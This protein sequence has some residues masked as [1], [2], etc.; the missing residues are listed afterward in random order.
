MRSKKEE[1]ENETVEE[2]A[3]E[4]KPVK[5]TAAKST[6]KKT[7]TTT[8]KRTTK[9][10]L[11]LSQEVLVINMS[12]ASFIYEARKGNGFLE[13]DEYLDSDYM[14]IED[15]QIMKNSNRG[16][17]EKGWLFVDDKEAVEFLGIKKYMD[18]VL[19]PEQ[20]NDLFELDTN[21]L[22]EELAKFSSS[23]KENIYQT[24][25]LKYEAGELTN[26]HVIRAIEE[27]L[28]VD[29]TLSVLNG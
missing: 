17:F 28:N 10:K 20:L 13:L 8:R 15:L 2:V 27:S 5:K 23:I 25:K 9:P 19:L 22:K 16:I 29:Q 4:E 12:Q 21:V 26:V 1:V 3:N 7:T 11:D 6:A 14:T 18:K 24:M